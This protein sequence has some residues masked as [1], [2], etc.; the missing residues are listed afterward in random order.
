MKIDPF[1]HDKCSCSRLCLVNQPNHGWRCNDSLNDTLAC[2]ARANTF[3]ITKTATPTNQPLFY[4]HYTGQPALAGISNYW[5]ISL[6][7]SFTARMPLLTATSKFGLGWRRWSSQQCYL[8]L[9]PCKGSQY[10]NFKFSD[11]ELH[12]GLQLPL[13]WWICYSRNNWM[14]KA[15]AFLIICSRSPVTS[16]QY[17]INCCNWKTL[18]T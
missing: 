11:M 10:R 7:Q 2:D 4:G 17:E 13:L 9:S 14:L 5:R 6:V 15:T 12:L 3:R 16:A 8:H 18:F 1:V